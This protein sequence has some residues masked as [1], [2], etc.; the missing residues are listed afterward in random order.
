MTELKSRLKEL[1]ER[2]LSI[3]PNL[4]TPI[5]SRE[6]RDDENSPVASYSAFSHFCDQVRIPILSINSDYILRAK[7]ANHAVGG[8]GKQQDIHAVRNPLEALNLNTTFQTR[9]RLKNTP[10]PAATAAKTPLRVLRQ[11]AVNSEHPSP[12]LIS[13]IAADQSMMDL[14]SLEASQMLEDVDITLI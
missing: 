1:R 10:P 14:G 4:N 12:Q 5:V 8:T 7:I 2:R 3:N 9:S 11:A 13:F 6:S